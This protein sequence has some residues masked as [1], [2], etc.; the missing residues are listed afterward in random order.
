MSL[1]FIA[2]AIPTKSANIITATAANI[3]TAAASRRVV[4]SLIGESTSRI[5]S[6]TIGGVAVIIHT[7]EEFSSGGASVFSA[8]VPTGTTGDI[9][10]TM[11]GTVF[12]AP[13]FVVYTIDNAAVLNGDAP[14]VSTNVFK[15]ALSVTIDYASYATASS[16][17]SVGFLSGNRTPYTNNKSFVQNSAL[18]KRFV[19]SL[20]GDI[21][22]NTSITLSWATASQ[23]A[24]AVVTWPPSTATA[25]LNPPVNTVP[26]GQ[27]G[28]VNTSKAITGV[29]VNDPNNNLSKTQ[30]TAS[31]GNV[32]VSL[33]GA[34]VS[35]GVNNS[36]TFTIS[37][38]QAQINAALATLTYI[39]ATAGTYTITVLSTDSSA[40]PLT[41]TDTIAVTVN[42]ASPPVNT[43]PAAQTVLNNTDLAITGVSVNDADG[44]LA[45]TK[46]TVLN[47]TITVS[48]AGGATINLGANGSA[49]LTLIGTQTQINAALGTISYKS[50]LTFS[51]ADTLTVLS[52]DSSATPLTDSDNITITVTPQTAPV[53]TVPATQNAGVNVAKSITGISVT[54]AE[55]NLATTRLTATGGTVSV[56]L[57]GGAIIS[58]GTNNSAALTISGTQTQINAA[59]ATVSY[60]GTAVG[61]QTITVLSTDTT[62]TP[63]TDS[64]V[65]NITVK[66]AYS[67]AN[68]ALKVTG[69]LS[70]GVVLDANKKWAVPSGTTSWTFTVQKLAAEHTAEITLSLEGVASTGGTSNGS[71]NPA[72]NV[73]ITEAA[74]PLLTPQQRTNVET[75][76]GGH[77]L[78]IVSKNAGDTADAF[79]VLSAATKD[80]TYSTYLI[81]QLFSPSANVMGEVG[82]NHSAFSIINESNMPATITAGTKGLLYD[83]AGQS[84]WLE[85][86]DL[87]T[88][89]DGLG[90]TSI[91]LLNASKMAIWDSPMP[92][93]VDFQDVARVALLTNPVVGAAVIADGVQR[94]FKIIPKVIGGASVN[95]ALVTPIPLTITSRSRKPWPVRDVRF[96]RNNTVD[97]GSF[98][99]EDLDQGGT[100]IFIYPSSRTETVTSGFYQPAA[101]FETGVTIHVDVKTVGGETLLRTLTA[102]NGTNA[103]YSETNRT[104]DIQ[105][106]STQYEVYTKKNGIESVR[107]IH[108]VNQ[109]ITYNNAVTAVNATIVA[110]NIRGAI[111]LKAAEGGTAGTGQ[112][113]GTYLVKLSGTLF[114]TVNMD[115]MTIE[116]DAATISSYD[117]STGE[118][119]VLAPRALIG[120][121]VIVPFT[122]T[123]TITVFAGSISNDATFNSDAGITSSPATI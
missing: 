67:I 27:T 8:I 107:F 115:T 123:G 35:A 117:N 18:D 50:N 56:S 69:E 122:G 94:F 81:D 105:R 77:P 80:G 70:N 33:N 96:T 22:G 75:T 60:T 78:F 20:N 58:L 90:V 62:G 13:I 66:D 6:A 48:L 91:R 97:K 63:L 73:F 21:A 19:G 87:S 86:S 112:E 61:N 118:L 1:I 104:T 54:D 16:L 49:T 24:A 28:V 31:S 51:G 79:D 30:V 84:E 45:S 25:V 103:S 15:D 34:T 109:R 26:V 59:L 12:G 101:A 46:L 7:T 44:N 38:T 68:T 111:T 98:P 32:S 119:I 4:V 2:E 55:N 17:L 76:G 106:Y 100:E 83:T 89:T 40:T 93:K 9:V 85:L 5:A 37:G 74:Y 3:G 64:D 71:V 43:V 92:I 14:N 82:R 42:A 116:N 99:E 41:D 108:V 113:T 110:S 36:S 57:I 120:F 102:T 29:R 52:T 53:N 95:P 88:K 39:H 121:V 114:P 65:I 47:G 11:A 23:G 72:T 10:A